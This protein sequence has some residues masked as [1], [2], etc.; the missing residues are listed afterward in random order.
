MKLHE[1]KS[2]VLRH[3]AQI[4]LFTEAGKLLESCDTL[5][6]L[7]PGDS[8]FEKFPVLQT[9]TESASELKS[10]AD[11]HHI[12]MVE[13]TD[14]GIEYILDLEISRASNSD[15]LICLILNNTRSYQPVMNLKQRVNHTL[16]RSDLQRERGEETA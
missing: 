2:E 13:F 10:A 11:P 8:V 6:P 3:R 16:Y 12:P 1:L 5:F 9:V 7:L 14:S 15:N 4:L